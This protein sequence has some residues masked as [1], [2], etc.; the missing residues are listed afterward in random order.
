MV[1]HILVDRTGNGHAIL[2]NV[3]LARVRVE[4]KP[5]PLGIRF[6]QE[7]LF[8][9]EI[10]VQVGRVLKSA[11]LCLNEFRGR[12][13]NQLFLRGDRWGFGADH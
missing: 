2:S 12:A 8:P 6:T 4:R 9:K 7:V 11:F 5:M 3:R 1:P 10:Q 13:G